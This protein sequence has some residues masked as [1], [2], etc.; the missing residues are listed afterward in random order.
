MPALSDAQREAGAALIRR[1]DVPRVH[2]E[3]TYDREVEARLADERE[4][5][6]NDGQKAAISPVVDALR[7]GRQKLLFWDAPA[8]TGK[9]FCA[10]TLLHR[11]RGMRDRASGEQ[12]RAIA[13]ASS[14]IAAI[15]LDGGSTFHSRFKAP[16]SA[17]K[18]SSPF[19]VTRQSGLGKAIQ[20]ASLILWDEAPMMNRYYLEGL[21]ML[22][23]DLSPGKDRVPFGGKC[24]VIAGDFRQCLPVV[25]RGGRAQITAMSLKKSVL[26][27]KFEVKQLTENMRLAT[28]ADPVKAAA[29]GAWLM[30]VGNGEVD[31]GV[32]TEG[33][34]VVEMPEDM[35]CETPNDLIEWVWPGLGAGQIDGVEQGGI[36]CTR[37]DVANKI[38]DEVG[39]MFPG[40]M[41]RAQSADYM[42]GED[43]SV[44]VPV[45]FLNQQAPPGMPPHEL[46][47][48][49]GMPIML[50]RNLNPADK[51]CNGTR[52]RVVEILPGGKILKATHKVEVAGQL[53]E[54]EVLIP[55]IPLEPKETDYNYRWRR[56]QFPVRVAFAMTVNKSQGQTFKGR[57]GVF[58]PE[59]VFGHGQLYVAASR[60]TDPRNIRFCI[61]HDPPQMAEVASTSPTVEPS[62]GDDVSRQRFDPWEVGGADDDFD[63]ELRDFLRQ[64]PDYR[65]DYE[66]DPDAEEMMREAEQ[67]E[68]MGPR[69]AEIRREFDAAASMHRGAEDE[70]DEEMFRMLGG[71][72]REYE[73][74]EDEEMM[75][76]E[77]LRQDEANARAAMQGRPV[78]PPR[79]V[80]PRRSPGP[81]RT[82]N[83]VY[84]EALT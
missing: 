32:D 80:E 59:P 8:G 79:G 35:V 29:Y 36:L 60:V 58:L 49:K 14:G 31:V 12:M 48:K 74:D 56:V 22:L 64:E 5:L 44:A 24:I 54:R 19:G 57:V 20:E 6:M 2:A 23:K 38:N 4:A 76:D 18:D 83:V 63:E 27:P 82:R 41:F 15:L 52:L 34:C 51:L 30:R 40:E 9:T 50:L 45:E 28:A 1:T 65:A 77:M 39:D 78:T 53:E 66:E 37:N 68:T 62:S 67:R 71:E 42:V 75:A 25:V 70:A 69:Y 13:V 16:L 81:R 21:D 3:G 17:H 7:D 72:A 46:K 73:P 33:N 26:W 10:N 43:R 61:A 11:V 55:R 47:L 84:K